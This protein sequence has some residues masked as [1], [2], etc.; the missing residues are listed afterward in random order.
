MGK[1]IT[2]RKKKIFIGLF[3]GCALIM[4][5]YLYP[6]EESRVVDV[7][8]DTPGKITQPKDHIS[9]SDNEINN[10]PMP[11]DFQKNET[12][13]AP[14]QKTASPD[15]NPYVAYPDKIMELLGI[16][17]AKVIAGRDAFKNT[18]IHVEWMDR[19]NEVLQNLDPKKKDA[20]IKNHTT[21]LYIKDLLNE[22][23]L[24]GKMDHE[25]FVKAVA[26]LMKWNQKTYEAL[27]SEAEYEALFE[28]K[29]DA[30]DGLID[31]MLESTPKYSFILNQQIPTEEVTKQVQGFKLEQVDAHFKKMILEREQIGKKI[32]AGEMTLEQAREALH[33]SQQVF[34]AKCK[35]LLTEDEINTIFGSEAALE[36][37]GTQAEPPPVMGDSDIIELGFMIE[38]PTTSIEMVKE[39]IDQKKLEDIKFFYQQMDQEKQELIA[40]LDAGEVK[41]DV[42]DNAAKEMD[43]A[44]EENCRSILTDEEYKLIFDRQADVQIQSSEN[45]DIES[46]SA[47]P[48]NPQNP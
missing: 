11:A 25:T 16:D 30:A 44:F 39:K 8:G 42:F 21:L 3:I 37:G 27:L 34:I 14:L 31:E 47:E 33:K 6:H 10:D 46:K 18:V 5:I 41:E 15:S 24:S 48:E 19:I 26:D 17:I 45:I 7:G 4:G 13:P 35:E 12:S 38:N 28:V 32:N 23:Y 9:A 2:R 43:K 22:A 40:K 1:M 36:T 20:I 29:P